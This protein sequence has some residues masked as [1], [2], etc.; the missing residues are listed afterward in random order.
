MD[1]EDEEFPLAYSIDNAILMHRDSH[2]SGS[3]DIMLDYYEKEGKGVI[4]DFTIER[5][6]ELA[7]MEKRTHTNMAAVMLSGPEAERVAAAK[8]AYKNIRDIYSVTKPKSPYPAL[9]ADLILSES[10]TASEEIAAISK[11]G[12]GIVPSLLEVLRNEDFYDPLFP[13]Y[14]QA[15]ALAA[16]CLGKI[17]DKRSIISLFEAIGEGDFFNEDIILNALKS[18][19]D[20]AR[21]F[22]LK[23][24]HG[25]PLNSDNERAA[26]AL[27]KFKDDPEVSQACLKMLEEIDVA[28]DLPLSTY[29]ILA[30]EGLRDDSQKKKFVEL[31]QNPKF[32]SMLK[33]DIASV[34]SLWSN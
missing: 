5:I 10:E 1:N 18:V 8:Q 27:L 25:R 11:E 13:G 12:S 16:E 14:G 7:E 24:L 2:F 30:C 28:K 29:L 19:G 17:G 20:P 15:P 9:I 22:L 21:D 4:Q 31:A 32:P 26:I 23:V 3:F 34:S 6:Q 33:R